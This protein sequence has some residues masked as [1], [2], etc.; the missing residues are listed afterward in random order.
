MH[1]TIS[2]PCVL[3]FV[4]LTTAATAAEGPSAPK[5]ADEAVR[6]VAQAL[7]DNKPVALWDAL[8]AGYQKDATTIVHTL[9]GKVDPALYDAVAATARKAAT[10][11]KDKKK[12][13]LAYPAVADANKDGEVEKYFDAAVGLIDILLESE[14]GSHEKARTIDLGAYFDKT[15]SKLAAQAAKLARIAASSGGTPGSEL[16][17]QYENLRKTKATLLT[18]SGDTAKVRIEVAGEAPMDTDFTRVEGKWIPTS[19]VALWKPAIDQ[20]N[21]AIAAITAEQMKKARSASIPLL[22]I[23]DG[24]L[25]TLGKAQTQDEFNTVVNGLMRMVGAN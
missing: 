9:V 5:S 3:T 18:E 20:A 2:W 10:I 6:Q 4:L 24:L 25:D 8:P 23:A 11:L 12:L 14:L 7:A 15:G 22:G 13:I 1:R 21:A 16:L 17:A 19:L